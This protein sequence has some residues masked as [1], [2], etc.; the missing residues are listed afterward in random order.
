MDVVRDGDF[1]ILVMRETWLTGGASDQKIVGDVTPAGYGFHRTA[2]THRKG[3]GVGILIRDYLKLQN[4]FRFEARSFENY[5]LTFTSGGV[6][7]HVA[8]VYRL[9]PS[10]KNGLKTVDFFREFSEFVDS[11]ATNSGHLLILGDFSIH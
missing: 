1:D 5:Q 4:H 10:K 8:I 11:L 9:Y 2:R 3:Q 7:V 6:S